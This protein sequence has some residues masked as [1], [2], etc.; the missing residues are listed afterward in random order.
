MATGATFVIVNNQLVQQGVVADQDIRE[1]TGTCPN[2]GTTGVILTDHRNPCTN[3][4][5]TCT[6]T[7]SPYRYIDPNQAAVTAAWK[8][9]GLLTY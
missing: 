4:G 9:A 8:A 5:W 7:G 3:A 6:A 1:I 2:C